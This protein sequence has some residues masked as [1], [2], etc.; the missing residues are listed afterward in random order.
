[1]TL[2]LMTLDCNVSMCSMHAPTNCPPLPSR[3]LACIVG[4]SSIAC[5]M[6]PPPLF[7][8]T[9]PCAVLHM[10]HCPPLLKLLLT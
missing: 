8:H 7:H 4:D 3:A 2:F 6:H 10:M 5:C 9:L 1:M